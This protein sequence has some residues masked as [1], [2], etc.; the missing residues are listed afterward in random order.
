MAEPPR[1]ALLAFNTVERLFRG[2][3]FHCV[4]AREVRRFLS[5][6]PASWPVV[7]LGTTNHEERH[8]EVFLDGTA[9]SPRF[10]WADPADGDGGGALLELDE[11]DALPFV[12]AAVCDPESASHEWHLPAGHDVADGIARRAEEANLGLAALVVRGRMR[13][14]AYQVMCHI[15]IGGT[16]AED[17]PVARQR[18]EEDATWEAVGIYAAN[19]TVQSVVSHGVAAVHLHARLSRESRGGH[20][21]AAVAGPGTAVRVFPL[22]DLVVRIRDLDEA[23][24]AARP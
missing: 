17:A 2:D 19:A 1:S 18:H 8:G 12:A 10:T 22:R 16:T 6:Y 9:G 11:A 21:N 15:P 7:G 23:M 5:E 20:V 24:R 4:T 14:V 3:F 13:E